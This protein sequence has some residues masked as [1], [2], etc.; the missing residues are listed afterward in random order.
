MKIQ[1]TVTT[2][3]SEEGVREYKTENSHKLHNNVQSRS[4][5]IL[6][7]IA[8][9]VT[10][11]GSL[12]YVRSLTLELRVGR[13]LL[14]VLFGVIPST[15]R[16]RHGDG[17]LDRGD[18]RTNQKTRDG[19]NTKEDTSQKWSEDNHGTWGDHLLQGST[20][21]DGNAGVV[22]RALSW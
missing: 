22:V 14:D 2:V 11:H 1:D 21:R 16:V 20:S 18:Q 17:K 9:S 4:R 10:N 5:C 13:L 6:E 7:R 8:D 12:V 3:C 15:S 19:T